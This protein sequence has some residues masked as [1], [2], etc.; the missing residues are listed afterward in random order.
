[1]QAITQLKR[2]LV[3]RIGR[4]VV[5]ITAAGV[6]LRGKHRRRWR[7]ASWAQIAGLADRDAP[8]LQA[9]EER[10]GREV[11]ERMGGTGEDRRGEGE[12]ENRR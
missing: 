10:S 4:L 11:L 2:P 1:M 5:R 7:R 8:I 3:R 9:A 12:K 6:E